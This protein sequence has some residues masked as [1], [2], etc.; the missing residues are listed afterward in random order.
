MRSEGD[1]NHSN[2]E[3]RGVTRTV[4]DHNPLKGIIADP[5]RL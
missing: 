3:S 1:A 2:I 4:A 5:H